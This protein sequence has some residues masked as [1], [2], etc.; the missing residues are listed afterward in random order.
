MNKSPKSKRAQYFEKVKKYKERFAELPS[1]ELRTRLAVGSLFKEAS[2]A[3]REILKE[4]G[5]PSPQ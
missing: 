5:E 3:I 2:V 4:R 1:A